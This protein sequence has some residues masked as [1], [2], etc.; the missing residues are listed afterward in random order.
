M[1]FLT[2]CITSHGFWSAYSNITCAFGV[3]LLWLNL[4][5]NLLGSNLLLPLYPLFCCPSNL[6]CG[7]KFRCCVEFPYELVFC[8]Q[9]CLF[10]VLPVELLKL[11]LFDLKFGLELKDEFYDPLLLEDLS[12][13]LSKD[14]FPDLSVDLVL[15]ALIS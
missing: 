8:P 11:L 2:V 7:V 12:N 1:K 6:L 14:L 10:C 5:G 3:D 13:D 4:V 15:I 9:P